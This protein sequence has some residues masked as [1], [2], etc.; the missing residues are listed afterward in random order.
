MLCFTRIRITN[1]HCKSLKGIKFGHVFCH[2]AI[3]LSKKTYQAIII[4]ELNNNVGRITRHLLAVTTNLDVVE[5]DSGVPQW[6]TRL[7]NHPRAATPV[8]K[9]NPSIR[10][11]VTGGICSQQTPCLVEIGSELVLFHI[12]R[13]IFYHYSG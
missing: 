11:R 13:R 10:V 9:D 4:K 3:K 7:G 1:K 8:S 12:F 6:T 5:N 2:A